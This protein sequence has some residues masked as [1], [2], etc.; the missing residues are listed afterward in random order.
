MLF[1]VHLQNISIIFIKEVN[2][3]TK[4]V[5]DNVHFI[6]S[7]SI[8]TR[9]LQ[10]RRQTEGSALVI[11]VTACKIFQ[12]ETCLCLPSSMTDNLRETKD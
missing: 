8:F 6:Y 10:F 2:A 1:S 4:V 3:K 7:I 9:T 11:N 12:T 5:E